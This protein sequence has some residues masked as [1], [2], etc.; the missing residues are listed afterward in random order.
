MS[1]KNNLFLIIKRDLQTIGIS[2]RDSDEIISSYIDTINPK[3]FIGKTKPEAQNFIKFIVDNIK[4]K[5]ISNRIS[6]N[7]LDAIKSKDTEYNYDIKNDD[8][9]EILKKQ[10]NDEID[11]P[12]QEITST[13]S[14]MGAV[15][16]AIA[17]SA[18]QSVNSILGVSNIT[19][20]KYSINPAA[21]EKYVYLVLDRKYV[22]RVDNNVFRWEL[23]KY[24]TSSDKDNS[25]GTAKPLKNITKIKIQPFVFPSTD[26][27]IKNANRVTIAIEEMISQSYSAIENNRRYHHIFDF[28]PVSQNINTSLNLINIDNEPN[29]FRFHTPIKELNS[30]TMTFGNPFQR[31]YLDNDLVKGNIEVSGIYTILKFNFQHFLAVGDTIVINDFTTND[32]AADDY[33]IKMVNDSNGWPITSVPFTNYAVIDLNLSYLTGTFLPDTFFSIYFESKRFI[34]NME[35]TMNDSM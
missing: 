25:V 15:S 8:I 21:N 7:K 13:V 26:K 35:F 16:N 20:M 5:I 32:P 3:A 6:L 33:I 4:A 18:S 23:S 29:V 2:T 14:N 27:L 28:T 19:E 9:H 12:S 24:T 10:M 31:L 30:I 1:Y 11:K 22:S 17:V 34:I